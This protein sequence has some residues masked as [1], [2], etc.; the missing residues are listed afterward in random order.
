MN[1]EKKY[2]L[3]K[4]AKVL[5]PILILCI[6]AV[7]QIF[8]IKWNGT[9]S[10]LSVSSK[11][12]QKQFKEA[13]SN[14]KM[15]TIYGNTDRVAYEWFYDVGT[16]QSI[17]E[18]NLTIYETGQWEEKVSECLDASDV[19]AFQFSKDI[20]LNGYPVLTIKIYNQ[21]TEDIVLYQLKDGILSFLANPIVNL[22]ED[23]AEISYPVYETEGI[24]CLVLDSQN[25]VAVTALNSTADINQSD[26]LA[27]NETSVDQIGLGN[28]SDTNQST[29]DPKPTMM[30]EQVEGNLDSSSLTQQTSDINQSGSVNQIGNEIH[31]EI[32]NENQSSFQSDRSSMEE[33]VENADRDSLNKVEVLEKENSSLGVN[34][35]DRDN[36]LDMTTKDSVDSNTT[37]QTMIEDR[38]PSGQAGSLTS[39]SNTTNSNRVISN[40]TQS[41]KDQYET[42]P[43]PEG[44]PLP[45]E[46]ENQVVNHKKAYSCTLSI[47]CLTI[48]DNLNDLNSTKASYVPDD[49]YIMKS[50]KVIFYEGESVFD[51]LLRETQKAGIPM[52]YSMTPIYN[53]NYI[54]GINNLYEFDCGNLSGWMYSVNG[55]YPNYGCSRYV[56]SDGEEIKWRYTCDLGRDVGC[57]WL[58]DTK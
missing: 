22:M 21:N 36:S 51:V 42:D 44:K 9:P 17:Y 20:N 24:L 56:L 13:L 28:P 45:V 55:W 6:V 14:D 33:L 52:E 15:L 31:T 30:A 16:I 54:E 8:G 19:F 47:D 46:P 3:K 58:D 25:K 37:E 34:H 18:T 26:F 2:K 43:V 50:K 12:I 49:G 40:G 53:S 57:E 27:R 29:P 41:L 32:S 35:S 48:K 11:E 4:Y 23:G 10:E 39:S 7:V 1:E 5:L 38:K